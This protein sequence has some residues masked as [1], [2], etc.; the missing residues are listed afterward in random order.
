MSGTKWVAICV[1]IIY[2][3]LWGCSNEYIHLSYNHDRTQQSDLLFECSIIINIIMLV[4][5]THVIIIMSYMLEKKEE[6]L[7]KKR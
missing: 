2:I 6:E 4:L 1:V 3:F 7:E 5:I